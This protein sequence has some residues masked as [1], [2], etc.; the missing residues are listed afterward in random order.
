MFKK[1]SHIKGFTIIEILTVIAI[2]SILSSIVIVSASEARKN[3]KI[4]AE[5]AAVTQFELYLKLYRVKTDHYP[6]SANNCSACSYD[7]NSMA[8]ISEWEI[9]ADSLYPSITQSPIY[10]DV[11]GNPYAYD[12]NYR[13]DNLA[14]YTVLCSAGP[15]GVLQTYLL[16]DRPAD[17]AWATVSNPQTK[18]DDICFF[19]Q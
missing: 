10:R 19:T 6:P 4:K 13:F 1:F 11:W 7:A 9:V 15:D 8:T 18:G 14:Y 12:N 2:I 17:Y 16:S 3:S 5:T